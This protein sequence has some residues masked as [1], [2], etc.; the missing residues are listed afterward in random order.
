VDVADIIYSTN[1]ERLK[2]ITA[3]KPHHL[4]TELLASDKMIELVNERKK[5][6]FVRA[7]SKLSHEIVEGNESGLA[8]I[9]GFN[10]R[11]FTKTKKNGVT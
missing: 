7:C 1:V 3:G 6:I 9:S 8:K 5:F 2:I 4:S 10:L 11:E